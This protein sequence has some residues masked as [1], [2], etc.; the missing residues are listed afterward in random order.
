MK[1]SAENL[2]KLEA[3]IIPE[4]NSGCWLWVAGYAYYG[5]AAAK[6]DGRCQRVHR[7]FYEHFV[8]PI[9]SG[10]VLDHLCRV[11]C[12]VNPQHL[13]PVTNAENVR[14]GDSGKFQRGKTHCPKG[15]EYTEGNTRI[16]A[17]GSRACRECHRIK[18]QVIN[19]RISALLP[20]DRRRKYNAS[21]E[22]IARKPKRRSVAAIA[23]KLG[24][25][26]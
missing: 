14:R 26:I 4:P 17:T 3:N 20:P 8:G 2:A 19:R 12:C 6:I 13:E 22:P 1:L 23:A 5:Y 15:H 24:W 25:E 10:L 7:V 21:S 9:P 11:T 16:T 18:Q